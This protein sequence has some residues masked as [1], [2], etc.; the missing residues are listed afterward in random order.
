MTE[1]TPADDGGKTNPTEPTNPDVNPEPK[2]DTSVTNPDTVV[3]AL[4]LIN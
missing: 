4:G 2:D 3:Q 1:P